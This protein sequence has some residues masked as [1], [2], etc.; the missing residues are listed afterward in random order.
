[1]N[2]WRKMVSPSQMGEVE[3][4]NIEGTLTHH[5]WRDSKKRKQRTKLDPTH[6]KKE[7][8]RV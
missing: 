6:P 2:R 8:K 4:R 5:N 3:E 7:L 1:M